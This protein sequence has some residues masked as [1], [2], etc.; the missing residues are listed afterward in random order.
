MNAI[1]VNTTPDKYL[2]SID[3]TLMDKPAFR[4]FFERLRLEVLA[5][6]M[7]T[8]EADLQQI[9]EKIKEG[10]WLKNKEAVMLRLANHS[11]SAEIPGDE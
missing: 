8:D 10:W 2:I 5:D 11:S 1:T 9:S 6:S 4:T 7:D 3:R